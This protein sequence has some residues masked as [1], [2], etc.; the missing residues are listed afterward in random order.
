MTSLRGLYAITPDPSPGREALTTRVGAAIA[1]GARVIQYREKSDD[2]IRRRREAIALL[3]ICRAAEIPLLINDDVALAADIG[4]PG[5]HI[6]RED[7]DLAYARHLLG[8]QAIIG[9]SCYNDLALARAAQDGGATYAA[10]GSFFVSPTKPEAVPADLRVLLRAHDELD[11]PLV[12]IGG[13]TLENGRALIEAG[14]HMLA[15]ISAVFGRTDVRAAAHAFSSLFSE[16][17]PS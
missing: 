9:V 6:G 5:V 1:G 8:D 7:R 17:V 14:A 2:R 4:A 3:D 15:V 11:I 16:D 12:A 10:F 13:I